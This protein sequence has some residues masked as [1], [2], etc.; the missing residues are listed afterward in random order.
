MTIDIELIEQA[1]DNNLDGADIA[2]VEENVNEV[3]TS[4]NSWRRMDC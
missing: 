1:F 4:L 2:A 3:F